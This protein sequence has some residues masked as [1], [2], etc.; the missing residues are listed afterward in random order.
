MESS[1]K[2]LSFP[3]KVRIGDIT[4]RDGFQHEEKFISTEAKV[5]YAEQLIL[6]GIKS[7]EVTNYGNPYRMSQFRDADEIIKRVR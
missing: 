7:I 4:I 5:Y 2:T 3:K 1:Y 6:A